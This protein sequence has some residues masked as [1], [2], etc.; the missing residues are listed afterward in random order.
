MDPRMQPPGLA[1]MVTTL[2]NSLSTGIHGLNHNTMHQT[3]TA[4]YMDTEDAT[5]TTNQEHSTVAILVRRMMMALPEL[6]TDRGESGVVAK[7]F[8]SKK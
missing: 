6:K 1:H 7:P 5:G 3:E 4:R 2:A 8:Q